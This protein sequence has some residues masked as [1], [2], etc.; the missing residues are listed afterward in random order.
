VNPNR[1]A[2]TE[3]TKAQINHDISDF[4][5]NCQPLQPEVDPFK[6][7]V[8]EGQKHCEGAQQT[9]RVINS[10]ASVQYPSSDVDKIVDGLFK[11][12]YK[13]ESL[14]GEVTER[15]FEAYTSGV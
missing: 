3:L 9:L 10:I 1:A 7:V 4:Y 5:L 11:E 15:D 14:L 2:I 13:V 12:L 6:D 8:Q